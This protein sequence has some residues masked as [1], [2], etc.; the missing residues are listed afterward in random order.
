MYVPLLFY[1]PG[2]VR[3]NIPYFYD[4]KLVDYIINA[5][6][7]VATYGWKLLPMVI[8]L[9]Q[10]MTTV[11]HS[12]FTRSLFANSRTLNDFVNCQIIV[13][14]SELLQ[15]CLCF[16]IFLINT[17]LSL[18]F[19]RLQLQIYYQS[20]GYGLQRTRNLQPLTAVNSNL[21]RRP[22]KFQTGI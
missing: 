20:I 17:P 12:I 21:A 18:L 16:I 10:L 5:V 6:N 8:K 1:R 11:N 3:V 14:Y 2:F 4:D 22:V 13:N 15:N 7:M 9:N 19:G